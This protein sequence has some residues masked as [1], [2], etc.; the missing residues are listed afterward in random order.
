MSND[1]IPQEKEF[2]IIQTMAKSA[3]QSKFFDKLGNESGII[4]IMLYARELGLPP[5]QCL[6]GGMH[7]IQGKIELSARMMN[8][9]IRKA[10]HKIEIIRSTNAE[11]SIRGTRT[12]TGESHIESLTMSEAKQLGIYKKGAW[13]TYPSDMLF[14]RCIS[15]LARRLFADVIGT[16]YV[17]GEIADQ[18]DFKHDPKPFI[19]VT[20]VESTKSVDIGSKSVVEEKPPEEPGMGI[21]EDIELMDLIGDD[22]DY[23]NRI[24]SHYA[25]ILKKD[26]KTFFEIPLAEYEKIKKK[27]VQHNE[28]RLNS[29]ME[30][31]DA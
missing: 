31:V 24:F 13:D 18:K 20:E 12:D 1:L 6:M 29:E 4:S 7:N 17:E 5:M 3:V 14:A 21:T 23:R 27:I 19:E 11:C 26:V 15:R 25:K 30:K 2:Q 22:I 28:E 16:A 9:M 10:G 8:S